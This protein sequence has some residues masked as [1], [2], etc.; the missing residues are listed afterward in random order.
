MPRLRLSSG[1][2]RSP[3]SEHDFGVNEPLSDDELVDVIASRLREFSPG[4]MS[5]SAR[6]RRGPGPRPGH[7]VA[8]PVHQRAAR[9]PGRRAGSARLT[10]YRALIQPSSKPAGGRALH[11]IHDGD[12]ASL[13]G[14]PRAQLGQ[15]GGFDDLVCEEC[16]EWLPKRRDFST[17]H[18]RVKR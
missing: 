6:R 12:E 8:H 3:R 14:I 9:A 4:G 1:S 18:P 10:T 16:I 13:C 15:G 17:Q 2:W 7:D 11:L 5:F